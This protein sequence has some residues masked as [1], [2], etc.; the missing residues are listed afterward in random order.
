[1]KKIFAFV[2][3]VLMTMMSMATGFACEE[4]WNV[5]D[6]VYSTSVQMIT[7]GD[8]NV[9]KWASLD[10][11]ICYQLNKGSFVDVW[12]FYPADDGRVWCQIEDE[13]FG[14]C[15]ISMKYLEVVDET[16]FNYEFEFGPYMEVTGGSVNVREYESIEAETDGVLHNGDVVE[17]VELIP[18]SDGRMW[19]GCRDITTGEYLGWVSM[20][21][22]AVTE[23]PITEEVV[24]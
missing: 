12:A 21:Y 24:G 2:L 22:L 15:F 11:P 18:T 7:T 10:G 16:S 19:A 17:V 6:V 9:R 14:G 1:M 4:D 3:V 20:K 13:T 23:M 5:E 8:V